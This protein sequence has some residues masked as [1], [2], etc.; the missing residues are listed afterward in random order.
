[1]KSASSRAYKSAVKREYWNTKVNFPEVVSMWRKE[2][3]K[4]TLSADLVLVFLVPLEI[5]EETVFQEPDSVRVFFGE[6]N[7][8]AG[9]VFEFTLVVDFRSREENVNHA[10]AGHE[11]IQR[12][13]HEMIH[14]DFVRS[15]SD[16]YMNVNIGKLTFA[17][18]L[19]SLNLGG[20]LHFRSI[21]FRQAGA[22]AHGYIS[23][24]FVSSSF[25]GCGRRLSMVYYARGGSR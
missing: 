5:L 12:G 3:E 24:T 22:R 8:V 10:D 16:V 13:H 21:V 11:F 9:K 1:M 2:A 19:L 20:S 15:R 23:M 7:V 25:L 14:R 17:P 6:S 18:L 4:M